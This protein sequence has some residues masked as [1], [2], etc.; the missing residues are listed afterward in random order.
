MDKYSS[1]L[2]VNDPT[3]KAVGDTSLGYIG[4]MLFTDTLDSMID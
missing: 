1:Y 4:N 2:F 3:V